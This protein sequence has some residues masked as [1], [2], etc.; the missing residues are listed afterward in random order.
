M[1][2]ANLARLLN[3]ASSG[4]DRREAPLIEAPTPSMPQQVPQSFFVADS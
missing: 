2:N 3:Q 4:L 1:I